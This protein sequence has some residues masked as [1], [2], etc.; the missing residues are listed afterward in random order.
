MEKRAMMAVLGLVGFLLVSGPA[1]AQDAKGLAPG[2]FSL[3]ST[4]GVVDKK[5]EDG[6]S[7]L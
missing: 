2:W 6:K 7:V 1:Y 4:V 5:V 3:D